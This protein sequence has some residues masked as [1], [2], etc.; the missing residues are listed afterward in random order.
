MRITVRY[1]D[2]DAVSVAGLLKAYDLVVIPSMGRVEG[3]N[4][5]AKIEHVLGISDNDEVGVILNEY[6]INIAEGGI[7]FVA[8][9]YDG[10]NPRVVSTFHQEIVQIA[11]DQW[12]QK[13]QPAAYSTFA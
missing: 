13:G 8:T 9:Y 2:H 5:V 6:M 7:D 4:L 10:R 1:G 3:R 12:E 11:I